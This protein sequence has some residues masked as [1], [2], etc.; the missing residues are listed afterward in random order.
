MSSSGHPIE[1]MLFIEPALPLVRPLISLGELAQ[2]GKLQ[3]V[4]HVPDQ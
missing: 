2:M 3:Q 1:K 4:T